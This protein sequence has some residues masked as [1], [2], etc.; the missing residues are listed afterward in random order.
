MQIEVFFLGRG[1]RDQGR[2]S[3]GTLDSLSLTNVNKVT[4]T[5]SSLTSVGRSKIISPL[6]F[7]FFSD[8]FIEMKS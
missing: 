7:E 8:K 3:L 2:M 6:I 4:E 5:A 1:V